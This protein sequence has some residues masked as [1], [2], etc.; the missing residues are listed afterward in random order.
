ML[1]FGN[2]QKT[3]HT[4]IFKA[5]QTH[6]SCC[7]LQKI[8][9]QLQAFQGQTNHDSVHTRSCPGSNLLCKDGTTNFLYTRNEGLDGTR[10][11]CIYQ[12][13][14]D[15]ISI[16][17]QEGLLRVGGRLQQSTLPYQAMHQMILSPNHHFTK[18][19]V[20]AANIRLHHAGP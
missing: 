13:S 5:K 11:S 2:L 6:Q 3:Y 15:N 19:V 20:S 14:Q 12:F 8:D 9:Q 4:Q 17:D 16:L 18:L 7:L 1:H 10:R